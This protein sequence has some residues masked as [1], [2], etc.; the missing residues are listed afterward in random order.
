[1]VLD[2][3]DGGRKWRWWL[4]MAFVV[5][6][7]LMEFEGFAVLYF[8]HT[9]SAPIV[10]WRI[11]G[12]L[13]GHHMTGL[14]AMASLASTTAC[15][16]AAGIRSAGEDRRRIVLLTLAFGGILANQAWFVL[17]AIRY[18]FLSSQHLGDW[19]FLFI[20]FLAGVV[21]PALFA[22]AILRTE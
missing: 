5:V 4:L 20:D 14:A 15:L 3:V 2:G 8:Y 16:V 1:M 18:Q 17:A 13:A 9:V 6:M 12:V 22:Y 19:D 21:A 10:L 11:L 7:A